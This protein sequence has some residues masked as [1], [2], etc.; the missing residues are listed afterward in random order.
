MKSHSELAHEL[1]DK[2]STAEGQSEQM[3]D[4]VPLITYNCGKC[5]FSAVEIEQ[6]N[7][8]IDANHKPGHT[9]LEC[10]KCSLQLNNQADLE[11]HMDEAH[12][13]CRVF[14]CTSCEY[15]TTKSNEYKIHL[16]TQ[17]KTVHFSII[18]QKIEEDLNSNLN[19][20]EVKCTLCDYSCR[21]NFQLK[22]HMVK[23]HAQKKPDLENKTS[24]N[25]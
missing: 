7:T 1:G 17:H 10:K 5:E 12:I 6:V 23:I 9:V 21:L 14:S 11:K 24:Q 20:S 25:I 4:A 13:I 8:H 19:T 15:R 3:G 2:V 18:K 22:R 16:D